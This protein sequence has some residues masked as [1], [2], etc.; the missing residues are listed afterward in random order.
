MDCVKP[1]LWR[2]KGR[3][4]GDCVP[5]NFRTLALGT[6][7]CPSSYVSVNAGPHVAGRDESLN[8]P[9]P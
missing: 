1:G 7:A 8:H 4:W 2:G 5:L 6:G 3:E 9:D